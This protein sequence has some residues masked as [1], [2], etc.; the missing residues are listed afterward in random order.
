M[1]FETKIYLLV[2]TNLRYSGHL[3]TFVP[4]N[5]EKIHERIPI[6]IRFSSYWPQFF[7]IQCFEMIYFAVESS[8]CEQAA[9]MNVDFVPAASKS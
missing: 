7:T 4:L 5:Y 3:R 2:V 1:N 9:I 6:K 8:P